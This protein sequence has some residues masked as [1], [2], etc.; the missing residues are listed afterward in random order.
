MKATLEIRPLVSY[1][2]VRIERSDI[3]NYITNNNIDAGN[4]IYGAG[5]VSN[6]DLTYLT[7]EWVYYLGRSLKK[8]LTTVKKSSTI[9]EQ[10]N[11]KT[12]AR[13][14]DRSIVAAK[15]ETTTS[16]QPKPRR[17]PR[18]KPSTTNPTK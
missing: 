11:K 2:E 16:E 1:P 13:Q 17:K 15:K 4:F 10:N 3:E 8:S 18:R 9:K 6:T 7:G 12:S 5:H 14:R